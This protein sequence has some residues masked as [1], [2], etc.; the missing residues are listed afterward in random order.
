MERPTPERVIIPF[1]KDGPRNRVGFKE[2]KKKKIG[3]A[4]R[5]CVEPSFL[6][7]RRRA[8]KIK[9]KKVSRRSR[10]GKVGSGVYLR[11]TRVRLFEIFVNREVCSHEMPFH[12]NTSKLK[13]QRS[14][15]NQS[16]S[17]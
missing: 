4:A 15:Q 7:A 5:S 2:E 8:I 6:S 17:R 1:V 14:A 16:Q 10:A 13:I 12:G 3:I 11:T 9:K